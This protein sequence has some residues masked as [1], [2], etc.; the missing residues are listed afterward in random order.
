MGQK[1]SGKSAIGR[2]IYIRLQ[3]VT[4]LCS[5]SPSRY[6]NTFHKRTHQYV[7]PIR[8][9]IF[10]CQKVLGC[11]DNIPKV[12]FDHFPKFNQLQ[13]NKNLKPGWPNSSFLFVPICQGK[14]KFFFFL[15]YSTK[16]NFLR[17]FKTC[18][19]S[20]RYDTIHEGLNQ[21]KNSCLK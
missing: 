2:V 1:R 16:Y 15:L 20:N 21:E 3:G 8:L 18:I 9:H 4:T 6:S 14:T 5:I 17:K 10:G 12:V 11:L 19:Y 7:M 13:S